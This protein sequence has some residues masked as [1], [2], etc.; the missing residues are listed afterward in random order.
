MSD[1]H[2]NALLL[3]GYARCSSA[4]QE[5][6]VPGQFERIN[7][8]AQR[9]GHTLGN[10]MIDV[11]SAPPSKAARKRRRRPCLAVPATP[12]PAPPCHAPPRRASPRRACRAVS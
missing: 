3:V 2:C 1:R 9:H 8:Q 11:P 6:S 10:L 4:P 5:R 12:G 7:H